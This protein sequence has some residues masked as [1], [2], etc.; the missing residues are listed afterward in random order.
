MHQRNLVK[1]GKNSASIRGQLLFVI[2]H[3]KVRFLFKKIRYLQKKMLYSL[4]IIVERT[5]ALYLVCA[6]LESEY[7]TWVTAMQIAAES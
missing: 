7:P 4:A 6:T 2:F 5:R 1:C 3:R